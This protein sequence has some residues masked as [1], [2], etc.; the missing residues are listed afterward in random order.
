MRLDPSKLDLANPR[1]HRTDADFAVT[2]AR[3][4]GQGRVFYSTLGLVEAN[5][6]RPEMQTMIAEAIKWALKLVDADVTP[7]PAPR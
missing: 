1:V 3:M 4:Y 5:W 7:R 2:W 6:D